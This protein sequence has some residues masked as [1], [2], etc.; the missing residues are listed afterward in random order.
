[1]YLAI[2]KRNLVLP[3]AVTLILL[4]CIAFIIL[5]PAKLS[6]D[7]LDL[8]KEQFLEND[9]SIPDTV[10]KVYD[11]NK[12]RSDEVNADSARWTVNTWPKEIIIDNDEPSDFVNSADDY[13]EKDD[14]NS[15]DIDD[16][17]VEEES[18]TLEEKKKTINSVK[19]AEVR[20]MLDLRGSDESDFDQ[21]VSGNY[22]DPDPAAT[23]SYFN[24]GESTVSLEVRAR[25]LQGNARSAAERSKTLLCKGLQK[26]EMCKIL[27]KNHN[28]VN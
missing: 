15:I 25:R 28:D 20:Y 7:N 22:A 16:N 1:M 27:F 9:D 26:G 24:N 4:A 8:N 13:E 21:E 11:M 2:H 6:F 5:A 17:N 23:D 18:E 14:E 12:M 19:Q 10:I 3:L